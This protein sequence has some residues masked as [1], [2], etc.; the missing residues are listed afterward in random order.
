LP[1]CSIPVLGAGPDRLLAVVCVA[2]GGASRQAATTA[3]HAPRSLWRPVKSL[4]RNAKPYP[5][6]KGFC[7]RR[8]RGVAWCWSVWIS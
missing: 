3:R 7:A 4:S 8:L 5:A 2:A 6:R 1:S